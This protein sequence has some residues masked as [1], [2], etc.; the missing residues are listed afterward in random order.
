MELSTPKNDELVE[1]FNDFN[2]NDT[3]NDSKDVDIDSAEL[4][5][6]GLLQLSNAKLDRTGEFGPLSQPQRRILSL[7]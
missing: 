7:V 3:D 6:P 4:S 2:D 1:N 5:T